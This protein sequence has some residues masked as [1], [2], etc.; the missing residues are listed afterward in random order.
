MKKKIIAILI[1]VALLSV[2]LTTIHEISDSFDLSFSVICFQL[3]GKC[4]KIKNLPQEAL[5]LPFHGYPRLSFPLQ[6][7]FGTFKKD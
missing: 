4:R 3:S 1:A 6:D 2:G 7:G 5:C